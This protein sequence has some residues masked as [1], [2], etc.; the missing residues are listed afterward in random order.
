M[1]WL[2][3]WSHESIRQ[4]SK[5][6]QKSAKRISEKVD[7]IVSDPARF[8]LRLVGKSEY[9]LRVGDYRVIALLVHSEKT[10]LVLAVGHRSVI[11]EK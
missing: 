1:A 6:D 4:M 3:R 8:L 10:I 5:L 7:S 11:Y 9:R 2:V